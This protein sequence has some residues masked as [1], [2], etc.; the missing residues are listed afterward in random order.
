MKGHIFLSGGGD[1]EDTVA[2]DQKFF[3]LMPDGSEI[4]YIPIALNREAAGFTACYDWFSGCVNMHRGQ[5][6][7]DVTMILMED[8]IP[9]LNQFEAIYIGGGD[10]FK[11]LDY[12]MRKGLGTKLPEYI[13]SGRIVYGGSAGAIILGK[14]I[15]TVKEEN[16]HNFNYSDGLNL[17]G[18]L[19]VH[20]HY[21]PKLD[22]KIKNAATEVGT[23]VIVMPENA[24]IA[25]H[26][27]SVELV[28]DVLLFNPEKEVMTKE[29]LESKLWP[30]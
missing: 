6:K 7:I 24:G 1:R 16:E 9:D 10:T 4:L 29:Y 17:L 3:D 11:L 23:P 13:E 2:L 18:G 5:R 12:V 19:S 26:Q 14:T 8:E 21:E 20:C 25:I 30:R 22:E 15:N 28:G 27:D